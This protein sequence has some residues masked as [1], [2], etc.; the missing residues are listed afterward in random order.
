MSSGVLS[1]GAVMLQSTLALGELGERPHS[2][3]RDSGIIAN[4]RVVHI[5]VARARC[6]CV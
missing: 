1:F 6:P 3:H 4:F 2:P 5:V